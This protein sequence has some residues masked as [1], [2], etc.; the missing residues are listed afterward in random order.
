MISICN[1]GKNVSHTKSVFQ[2]LCIIQIN[3]ILLF[4]LWYLIY[5]DIACELVAGCAWF[6]TCPRVIL[7]RI[8]YHIGM[9]EFHSTLQSLDNQFCGIMNCINNIICSNRQGDVNVFLWIFYRYLLFII[10]RKYSI[11]LG[12]W[13]K[14][15]EIS[16][17][18]SH[19]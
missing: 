7:R 3:S 13:L 5:W 16:V 1:N 19:L 4:L 9:K 17:H 14:C 8:C 12:L 6:S 10:A 15:S 2:Q 11:I 18:C